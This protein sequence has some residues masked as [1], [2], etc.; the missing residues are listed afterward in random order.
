[1]FDTGTIIS[2][3]RFPEGRLAWLRPHWQT[4]ACVPLVSQ[5]TVRELVHVL[6]YPKLR[7]SAAQQRE[8]LADYLPFCETVEV[9][10]S[11]N[12][13]CRDPRDQIFLDLAEC[14]RAKILVSGDRDLLVLAGSPTF[15]IESPEAYRRRFTP[16]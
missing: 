16:E 15:V 7:L 10:A 6:N 9:T 2:A 5:A 11:S 13:T 14:G 8:L 4:L 3:L 1:M 12:V